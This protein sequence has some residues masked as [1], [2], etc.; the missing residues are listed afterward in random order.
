[1]LTD[2]PRPAHWRTCALYGSA[3]QVAQ[4]RVALTCV[5]LLH[6]VASPLDDAWDPRENAALW[7]HGAESFAVDGAP[8]GW[9]VL[10]PHPDAPGPRSLGALVARVGVDLTSVVHDVD[11]PWTDDHARWWAELRAAGVGSAFVLVDGPRGRPIADLVQ[12]V[13]A[14]LQALGIDMPVRFFTCDLE[15]ADVEHCLVEESMRCR[16]AGDQA[17]AEALWDETAMLEEL[18]AAWDITPHRREPRALSEVRIGG[19]LVCTRCGEPVTRPVLAVTED[20]NA[21]VVGQNHLDRGNRWIAPGFCLAEFR[22]LRGSRHWFVEE[23]QGTP[24]TTCPRGHIVGRKFGPIT[25]EQ[26]AMDPS[27][28]TIAALEKDLVT[29]G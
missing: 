18:V 12:R 6:G 2:E 25:G 20:E 10:H 24:I 11:A 4:V 19:L 1:M 28:W 16:A 22:W 5:S 17:T 13:Q 15:R 3:R 27:S 21:R 26:G 7:L 29:W 14:E 9:T 23:D 8:W